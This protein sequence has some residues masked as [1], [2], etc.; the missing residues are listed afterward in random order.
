MP[1]SRNL[2][3][4]IEVNL[5]VCMAEPTLNFSREEILRFRGSRNAVISSR[6][7]YSFTEKERNNEGHIIKYAVLLLSNRECPFTCL[8]C[9]L[10]KNTLTSTVSVGSIPEQIRKGLASNPGCDSIKLYNSGSFFDHN[11]IPVI[12]YP[13]IA[14]L[15]SSFQTVVVESHPAFCNE[16]CVSFR[17]LIDPVQLEVAIGLETCDEKVLSVLHKQMTLDDFSNAVKRLSRWG[18]RSRA[19]ILL[20]PPVHGEEEAIEWTLKSVRYAFQSGVTSCSIIPTRAGN[21]I[22]DQLQQEGH[23]SP[24]LGSSIERVMNEAISFGL[25]GN[26]IVD[27]WDLERFFPCTQCRMARIE[28]L[29]NMNLHQRMYE[30]V[31]CQACDE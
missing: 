31:N 15:V 12:D 6:P 27:L 11:A 24:P 21:G 16:D 25:P 9:D 7:Y 14:R 28:R 20:K 13:Q 23:F 4:H 17:D 19:F 8:M 18:I 26:V 1:F 10:W 29:S 2:N 30:P 5:R 22:M 3:Q